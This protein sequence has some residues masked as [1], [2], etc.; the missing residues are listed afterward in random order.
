MIP[1]LPEG[2]AWGDRR[3]FYKEILSRITS[4]SDTHRGWYTHKNPYGC[5]I[6]DLLLLCQTLVNYMDNTTKS[7]RLSD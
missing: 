7:S 5:W 1:Q 6:C 2:S 3:E 4:A